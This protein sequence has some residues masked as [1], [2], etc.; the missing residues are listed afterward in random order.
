MSEQTKLGEAERRTRLARG[1][2]LVVGVGGLGSP[3]ALALAEAGVGVIGLIDGDAVE[4]SNL[5][6]QVVHSTA[7][8]GRAKVDSAADF[9]RTRF[10]ALELHLYRHALDAAN[11]PR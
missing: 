7:T 10:P 4:L 8:L 5:Q 3:A 11:L 9:L 6:R 2:V 1:R